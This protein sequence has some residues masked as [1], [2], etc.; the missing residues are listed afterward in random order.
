MNAEWERLNET[1]RIFPFYQA[2]VAWR[3]AVIPLVT[4]RL[5]VKTIH[6]KQLACEN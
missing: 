1:K 2:G 6:Y 3:Q 4:V 5:Q